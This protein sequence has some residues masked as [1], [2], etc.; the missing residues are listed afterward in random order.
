MI[1]R[2]SVVPPWRQLAD[3]LRERIASGEYRPGARIPS[4]ASLAQEFELAPVTVR[5][6][7]VQLQD[8]GLLVSQVGWGTY[9]AAKPSDL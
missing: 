6:A 5:K 8:E 3:L 9:V 4:A 7:I 1:D 2:E